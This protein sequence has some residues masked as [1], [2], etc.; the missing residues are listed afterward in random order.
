MVPNLT[1]LVPRLAQ[2]P[3]PVIVTI[4]PRLPAV[5]ESVESRGL[6]L[7]PVGLRAVP[8]GVVTAILPLRAAAGTVAVICASEV[9][10]KLAAMPLNFTA[11]APVRLVPVTVTVPPTRAD[12]GEK[13]TIVG[14]GMTVEPPSHPASRAQS[15]QAA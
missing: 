8:S 13:P 10:V 11:V 5:G 2:K 1:E 4:T 12:A 3:V 7:K 6:T 9:T 14:V 15:H